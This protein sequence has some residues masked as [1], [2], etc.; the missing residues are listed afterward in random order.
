MARIRR[1]AHFVPGANEKMLTKALDSAADALVLDLEDA[2][3][4]ENKDEARGI[5]SGWLADV[6][7]GRHERVVR[8]NP[9]DSPWFRADLE[10][11][12]VN[13][14]DSYLVPKIYGPDEV[15][16][17]DRVVSELERQHGHEP[18]GVKLLVLGT[19]TARG[20]LSVGELACVAR[21]D[22]LTWGAEDLSAAIGARRNR[23]DNGRYLPIFEHART[24]C[25]LSAAAAGVQPLD[26]VFTDVTDPDALRSECQES[27]WMGFTGKISIHPSQIDVINEAFTPSKEEIEASRE[28]LEELEQQRAQGKMAFRFRGRMVDVPHFTQAQ[29][30]LDLAKALE[31][32]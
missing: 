15:R 2:V 14:P 11:T 6:D 19:E 3:T 25:L 9:T 5:I 10:A 12:M 31:M 1:C 24:M 32:D 4:P 17:I 16:L 30:I 18:G 23:Y 21:V 22:A 26:T 28:L 13:P 8:C 20:F 27:A 7:F 29:R